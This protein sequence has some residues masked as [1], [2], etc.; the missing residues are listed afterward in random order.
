MSGGHV[1]S[2]KQ[3]NCRQSTISGRLRAPENAVPAVLPPRCHP[4]RRRGR[5]TRAPVPWRER[6]NHTWT[7]SRFDAGSAG[8]AAPEVVVTG[9]EQVDALVAQGPGYE[10]IGHRLGVPAGQA[11]LIATGTPADGAHPTDESPGP[12][13]LSSAQRLV[14]PPHENPT[15]RS[16]VHEWIARRVAADE[17]M[18]FAG[19]A[20]KARSRAQEG[21]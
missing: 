20:A 13:T 7:A 15:S 3:M 2:N 6:V 14:N 21:N 17:Q 8:T 4:G 18:R 10:E 9:K 12:G 5:P 1:V 16:A 19:A 11:Y